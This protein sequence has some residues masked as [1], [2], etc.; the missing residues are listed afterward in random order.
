MK[1]ALAIAV[2]I[3]LSS[4]TSLKPK[5]DPPEETATSGDETAPARPPQRQ[6]TVHDVA[7]DCTSNFRSAGGACGVKVLDQHLSLLVALTDPDTV[8][9]YKNYIESQLTPAYCAA[10][11]RMD[12]AGRVYVYVADVGFTYHHCPTGKWGDWISLQPREPPDNMSIREVCQYLGKDP[13]EPVQC[14]IAERDGMWKLHLDFSREDT[15][16]KRLIEV[17]RKH[18]TVPFCDAAKRTGVGA[19]IEFH[20]VL[21]GVAANYNCETGKM[22]ND[23]P[24]KAAPPAAK[25]QQSAPAPQTKQNSNGTTTL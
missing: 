2:L 19:I 12:M 18:L 16:S 3:L 6:P 4:C 10:A 1:N 9:I 22:G 5:T 21:K 7:Q 15:A 20:N 25:Q 24:L 23:Y 8:D 17:L 14:N 13:V 11:V